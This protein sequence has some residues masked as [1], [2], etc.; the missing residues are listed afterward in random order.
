M[1]PFPEFN[2]PALVELNPM[3]WSFKGPSRSPQA[4]PDG[5]RMF[6][7]AVLPKRLAYSKERSQSNVKNMFGKPP[8]EVSPFVD[9]LATF[10]IAFAG[11]V[12]LIVPMVIMILNPSQ[13]KSLI[14]VSA[15]VILFAVVI[16]FTFNVSYM[17]TV[18]A[19]TAYAAVLVVFVGVGNGGA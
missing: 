10:F 17:D 15:A 8:K 19:T 5:L 2:N 6:L 16:A 14:T 18:T 4:P 13:A 12:A 7:K 3:Y 11:G 1:G 9:K